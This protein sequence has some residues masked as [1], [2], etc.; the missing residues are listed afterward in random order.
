M[1]IDAEGRLVKPQDKEEEKRKQHWAIE[2][3]FNNLA[4]STDLSIWTI[5]TKDEGDIWKQRY[6]RPT[7][8]ITCPGKRD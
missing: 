1:K 7:P 8:M 6:L 2:F 3:A 5:S 4:I